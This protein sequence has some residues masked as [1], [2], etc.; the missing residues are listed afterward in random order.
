[1]LR[2]QPLPR[3][4]YGVWAALL[5]EMLASVAAPSEGGAGGRAI[6]LEVLADAL[7]GERRELLLQQ[8]AIVDRLLGR[9]ADEPGGGVQE[10]GVQETGTRIQLA[11]SLCLEATARRLSAPG[12]PLV[13][14]LENLH[15]ADPAS[16]S[17]IAGV[18][19]GVRAGVP[20]FVVLTLR[21]ALP[22]DLPRDAREV[23]LGPL[24]PNEAAALAAIVAA[25]A[26]LS[27]AVRQLVA[28][29]AGGNPLFIEQLVVMLRE[30][31]LLG[32]SEARLQSVAAPVSLYGL[33]LER[34]DRLDT[35]LAE[36]LRLASVLGAEFERELYL[37][38]SEC[39]IQAARSGDPRWPPAAALDELCARGFL[40]PSVLGDAAMYA[41]EQPQMQAAV[42]GTVLSENRQIL[43]ALAAE[44]IERQHQPRLARHLAR[45]LYHYSQS[46]NVERTVQYARLAGE[47]ALAMAAYDEAGEQLG[48]AVALQDRVP[49]TA[50]LTAAAT[51]H[52]LAAA[53]EWM[54][55]L[56]QAASRAEEAATRLKTAT[57]DRT[58]DRE[59]LERHGGI[60]MTLG[61]VYGLL[62]DW[63]RSIDAYATAESSYRDA[64]MAVHAAEARCCR[65]FAHRARG[66]PERGA[67]L[68]REGW[69]V[70]EAT[71][72]RPA[73][74]RA[75][76]EL[77]NLLRDLKRHEEAL[78]IFDRAVASG[79]ELRREGRHAEST[80]GSIAARSG[81]AMTHAALGDLSAAIA[82][83]R[84]AN[85]LAR[86]DGNQVAQ[87]IS[88]YHLATH[89]LEQREWQ[90]AADH[91]ERAHDQARAMDMP[92]RA[93][94]SRL[95]QA[96]IANGIGDWPGAV[97][98]VR[99]AFSAADRGRIPDDALVDAME[100]LRVASEHVPRRMLAATLRMAWTRVSHG[101]SDRL[102][103]CVA[104]LAPLLDSGDE[105]TRLSDT[106]GIEG[107]E[108]TTRIGDGDETTEIGGGED[109]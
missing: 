84:E 71:G 15:R 96:R 99:E 63:E 53:L 55:Q 11:L 45:I 21:A 36:A 27:P 109:R 16:L 85:D 47:R 5:E 33:F 102:R 70:L 23:A 37:A 76:H 58:G 26:S 42:Y 101:G 41:F 59:R 17:L 49:A 105:V 3:V 66:Q 69:D 95:V 39:A 20:P 82:D 98:R 60:A 73:I 54:G 57:D 32:A 25:P 86:R 75:G 10:G 68:A 81:R 88:E 12:R 51:L 9:S 92:A 38:V 80:W 93:F 61:E 64:G 107:R 46:G 48:L 44:S 89:Y 90:T 6:P 31:G 77:G 65:G 87:A 50:G 52:E 24:P 106:T 34:V 56:R 14:V 29:R 30:E 35:A 94:K 18:V 67:E 79:D 74:A 103:A 83:Q 43:H 13:V 78:R 7:D 62:G 8:R 1:V 97:G 2:A 91:A 72:D 100:L 104:A 108:E 4:S 40:I 28:A 19:A 22:P